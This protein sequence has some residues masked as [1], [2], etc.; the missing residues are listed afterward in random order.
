MNQQIETTDITMDP[1]IPRT[2]NFIPLG[3]EL[4]THVDTACAAYHLG[5][6]P[7][8]LRAWACLENGPLRPT[9][10]NGRLSWPVGAIRL[11]LSID[12]PGLQVAYKFR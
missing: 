7:Q 4:R 6:R 5:R 1:R 8:T 2:T 10:I 3:Q 11:L 9:R 12:Q